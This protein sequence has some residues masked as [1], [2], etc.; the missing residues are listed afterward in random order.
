MKRWGLLALLWIVAASGVAEAKQFA[1]VI[2]SANPTN[3]ITSAELAKIFSGH[4]RSWPDGKA[5]TVVVRDP[6]LTDMQL[7]ARK[8][9]NMSPDQARAFARSH[10][11]FIVV[12]DSDDAVI[13]SVAT[14]RGAIGLVD[15]YSL[16]KDVNVVKVDG[17]LPVEQGYV[18]RGN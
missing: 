6:S 13:H 16:T 7:V 17:K 11:G 10:S 14:T 4:S 9:F 8:V 15:L 1:V 18:L 12:V 5:I 2:D 3:S